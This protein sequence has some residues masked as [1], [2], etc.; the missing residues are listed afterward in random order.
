MKFDIYCDESY[1]DLFT[2]KKSE[3]KFLVIG[4]LWLKAED[5]PKFKN[6]IHQLR[7]RHKIGSEFKWRKVS[8]SKLDF[9][10]NL[11]QWFHEQNLNLRFRSIIVDHSKVDLL[12]YH[13]NDHELGFYKFYYQMLKHWILDFN[14]YSIFCDYKSNRVKNRLDT[15]KQCLSYANLSS[16]ILAVQAT[17]ADESVFIQ[18]ADLLTGM[19]SAK[20]NNAIKEG[21]AKQ[22]ILKKYEE[23]RGNELTATPKGEEKFNI[24]KINLQGGW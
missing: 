19:V 15:L 6:E 4:S 11:V 14:E 3:N 20:F 9:Y 22:T 8:P 5:R 23:L 16:Q 1:P 13:D 21:T 2:S 24:F 12:K 17:R 7:N 10:M 18:L